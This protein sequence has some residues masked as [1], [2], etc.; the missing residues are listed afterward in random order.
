MKID[1][2]RVYERFLR[3][4]GEPREIALGLALGIFIGTLPIQGLQT[5]SAIFLAAL[6]KWSK[7]S[8]VMG[9]LV[10]NPLTIPPLYALTFF[11]GNKFLGL[12]QSLPRFKDFGVEALLEMVRKTPEIFLALLLGG[13]ILGLPAAVVAYFLSY[14]ALKRYQSRI[15]ESLA[16][17]REKLARSR[18]SLAHRSRQITHRIQERSARRKKQKSR[19][20][21]ARSR[22]RGH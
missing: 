3:I 14:E 22:S 7:I 20:P 12:S 21:P 1:L 15:G 16:L 8:A 2:R 18:E 9:T 10:T 5:V 4:R 11:L 6:F 17:Q 13:I 19:K